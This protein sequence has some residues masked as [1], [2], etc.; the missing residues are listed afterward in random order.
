LLKIVTIHKHLPVA[1]WLQDFSIYRANL[2]T[3]GSRVLTRD[4]NI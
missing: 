3:Y 1:I 2:L 4:V